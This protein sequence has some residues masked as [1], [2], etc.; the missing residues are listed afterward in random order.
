MYVYI[1]IYIHICIY[2]ICPACVRIHAAL[3]PHR[4]VFLNLVMCPHTSYHYICVLI[5]VLEYAAQVADILRYL[6]LCNVVHRDIKPENLLV[7]MCPHTV[8][9]AHCVSAYYVSAYYISVRMLYLC[10]HTVYLL[11]C[12]ISVRILYVSAYTMCP[13]TVCVRIL[14]MCSHTL[15]PHTVYVLRILHISVLPSH[16]TYASAQRR[17]PGHEG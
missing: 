1:Y 12:Y 13:L 14:H 3:L 6:H 4:Q 9:P 11:A 2:T 5:Q 17:A 15:C 16:T 8:S 7:Y 10:P